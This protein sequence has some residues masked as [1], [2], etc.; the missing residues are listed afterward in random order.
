MSEILLLISQMNLRLIKIQKK[1][2]NLEQIITTANS[3][4]SS[5]TSEGG[6]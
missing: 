6:V 1:L 2:D 5:E 3:E 4:S